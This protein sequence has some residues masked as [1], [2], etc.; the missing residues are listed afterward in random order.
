MPPALQQWWSLKRKP[1][2]VSTFS[3]MRAKRSCCNFVKA[4][5]SSVSS[6]DTL[7]CVN[8]PSTSS[9][10]N[11]ST[12][13]ISRRLSSKCVSSHEKPR[14]PMP[15]SSLMCTIIFPP[16]ATARSENSFAMA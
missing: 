5:L 14:R 7:K 11:E 1:L 15:V 16:S 12:R 3:I 8:T 13:R 10:G 9:P 2:C 4:T 6:S